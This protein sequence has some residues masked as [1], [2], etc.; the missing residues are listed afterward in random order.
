MRFTDDARDYYENLPNIDKDRLQIIVELFDE[1][2]P[3]ASAEIHYPNILSLMVDG[4][5]AIGVSPRKQY[6]SIYVASMESLKIFKE[7]LAELGKVNHGVWCLRFRKMEHIN[8]D[9]L[10]IIFTKIGKTDHIG[11]YGFS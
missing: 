9:T 1:C 2:V 11:L 4:K 10:R 6:L 8:L 7:N 5:G 3:N